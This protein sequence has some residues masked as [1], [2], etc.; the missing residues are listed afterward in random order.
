MTFVETFLWAF[1]VIMILMAAV[2]IAG[3]LMKNAGIVDPFRGFGFVVA[4]TCYFVWSPGFET[5]KII[6]LA[7][8]A[9]GG[10]LSALA[11]CRQKRRLSLSKLSEKPETI[12]L[13][14]M[15]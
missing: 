7:L 13:A 15:F 2:W 3:G 8:V 5:R 9:I 11:Q 4:A 1:P 12:A 14:I 10:G 6:V